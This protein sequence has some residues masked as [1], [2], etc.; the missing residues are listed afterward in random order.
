MQLV[1]RAG[2]RDAYNFLY[3]DD[4]VL[5]D[6][7]LLDPAHNVEL[8][9]AYLHLLRKDLLPNLP[10]GATLNEVLAA[11]YTWGPGNV[12]QRVL[13]QVRLQDLTQSQAST[14]LEQ[15]APEATRVYLRRVKDRIGLY[16]DVALTGGPTR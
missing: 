8:G 1:P 4:R 16:D 2:A 9:A 7:Y 6:S 3:R 10:A 12:R 11:A 5:D 14:V 15:R 13:R